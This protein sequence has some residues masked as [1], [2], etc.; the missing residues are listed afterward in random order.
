MDHLLRTHAPLSTAAW[1]MV[2]DEAKTRLTTQLAARKLVDFDGP[3]G[4]H[5]AAVPP[6]GWSGSRAPS[7][8]S[9]RASGPCSP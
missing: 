4:W 7:K 8:E 6:A 5:R 2:D 9:G 1:E 3:E